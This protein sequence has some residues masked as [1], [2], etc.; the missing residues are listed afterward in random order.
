MPTA[1]LIGITGRRYP[2]GLVNSDPSRSPIY[3]G[4]VLDCYFSAYAEKLSLAGATPVYLTREASPAAL[5]K[6]LDGLLLAGGQDVDPRLYGGN[7][8]RFSTLLDPELDEFEI[9]L[10]R[11]AV[12]QGVPLLGT[13]RGH[14]ILNVAFGGTLREHIDGTSGPRHSRWIYPLT[15]SG[16]AIEISAGSTMRQLYGE[17]AEVNSFHHQAVERL[18]DGI[19]AVAFASDDGVIEAIELSGVEA[20]GV[21]WHPEFAATAEPV[22]DWLAERAGVYAGVREREPLL[23]TSGRN[24]A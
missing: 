14:E 8:T 7:A 12:Q 22:L 3:S 10:A 2:A 24:E 5:I 13:C 9:A 19:E 15:D 21:Q 18:G 17:I 6:R 1:P 16:H 20:I 11:L 4:L 23:E